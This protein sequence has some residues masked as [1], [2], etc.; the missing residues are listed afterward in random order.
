M[1]SDKLKLDK[2]TKALLMGLLV[3]L[4][5]MLII[6]LPGYIRNKREKLYIISNTYRIKYEQGKWSKFVGFV[7]TKEKYNIYEQVNIKVYI[8]SY[9]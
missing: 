9:Y 3:Y 7:E 2:G 6:F 4:V 1:L 8:M 5:I